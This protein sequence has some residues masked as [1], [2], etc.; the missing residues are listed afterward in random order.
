[1]PSSDDDASASAYLISPSEAPPTGSAVWLEGC[2]DGAPTNARLEL[3]PAFPS[4]RGAW[5]EAALAALAPALTATCCADEAGPGCGQNGQVPRECGVDC[6]HLWAPYAAQCPGAPS[7][8][9][10]PPRPAAAPRRAASGRPASW[11][12]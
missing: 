8:R 6:A 3:A 5:C 7:R 11:R 2:D 9:P 10:A 4:D 1:M 12:G